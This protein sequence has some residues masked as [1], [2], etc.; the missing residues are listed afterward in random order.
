MT[1]KIK[2]LPANDGDC[3]IISYG[4]DEKKY[5]LLVDGGRATKDTL[6][7]L[8]AE[9]ETIK[10]LNQCIDL[11][12]VTH[13][14]LDH[15]D[16]I[17]KIFELNINKNLI[18]KVWFNTGRNIAK[19]FK[20]EIGRERDIP[21]QLSE[22]TKIGI[23]H[24]NSLEKELLEMNLAPEGVLL[25]GDTFVIGGALLNILSPDIESLKALN[26]IWEVELEED[27]DTQ[28]S[29]S[30]KTNDYAEPVKS[31]ASRSFREDRSRVNASSI[32]FL[33]EY[34]DE[35]I[36]MLGDAPPTIV[37]EG[38]KKLNYSSNKRLNVD[39]MKISHHGSRKNTSPHLLQLINCNRYIVSTNGGKV[40]R[41][42]PD[43]ECLSRVIENNEG[44]KTIFYFNYPRFENIFT[45]EEINDYG[46]E[47][48]DLS[49]S[50]NKYLVEG[51]ECIKN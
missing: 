39:L 26:E 2:V 3:F 16:G 8:K 41:L 40:K 51:K 49:Q 13:I 37:V 33:L 35:K 24:G 7:K 36:L 15:I 25:Q 46:I 14:D 11:L 5:N 30:T 44:E 47:C 32:A 17:L 6:R 23:N 12:I 1:I 48:H 34:G 43:K 27:E 4:E 19:Y 50:P 42:L 45:E 29:H 9:L 31:L 21:I 28:V 38:L 20:S 22:E 10:E 18:K